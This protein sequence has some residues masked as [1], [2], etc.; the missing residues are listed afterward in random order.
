ME[1]DVVC[2]ADL[3]HERRAENLQFEQ[4]DQSDD[5]SRVLEQPQSGDGEGRRALNKAGLANTEHP[6]SAGISSDRCVLTLPV[7]R[8]KLD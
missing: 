5:C 1:E 4:S 8:L 6:T 2:G 7:Y 3:D